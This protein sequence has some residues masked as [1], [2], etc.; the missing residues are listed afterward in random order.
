MLKITTIHESADEVELK[1]EGRITGQWAYLLD[2]ICHAYLRE[3]KKIQLDC[4]QVELIDAQGEKVLKSLPRK[5]VTTHGAP[6][7]V[8]PLQLTGE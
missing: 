2:G 6:H 3:H 7:S 1:L 5:R 4:A 8:T